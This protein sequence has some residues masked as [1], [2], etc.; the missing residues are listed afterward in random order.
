MSQSDPVDRQTRLVR[1]RRGGL[2]GPLMRRTES[3]QP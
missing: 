2:F 3:P 1:R